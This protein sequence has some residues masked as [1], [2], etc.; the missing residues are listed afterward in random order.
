MATAA[1][2][3]TVTT[4]KSDVTATAE[5]NGWNVNFNYKSVGDAKPSEF[6]V[7]GNKIANPQQ[8]FNYNKNSFTDGFQ[9]MGGASSLTERDLVNSIF[10]ELTIISA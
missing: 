5:M 1:R 8:A 10:D 2:K 4:E 9:F 7:T 3:S 6:S